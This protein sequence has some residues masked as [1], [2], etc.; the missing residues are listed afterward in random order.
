MLAKAP[1]FD[2]VYYLTL[3]RRPERR[4]RFC[5]DVVL[6]L[7]TNLFP[8]GPNRV[9]GLDGKF[10]PSIP[11]YY[12]AATWAC[13]QGHLRI[14]EHA[15]EHGYSRICVFE[16]DAQL[17]NDFHERIRSFLENVPSTWGVLLLG[18]NNITNGRL[19]P[20]VAESGMGVTG[21]SVVG[22][23]DYSSGTQCYCLQGKSIEN[24]YRALAQAHRPEVKGWP[25]V[26]FW[27]YEFPIEN[28]IYLPIPTLVGQA[29][30]YSDIVHCE[31]PAVF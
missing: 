7:P 20:E 21:P 22:I 9:L 12:S 29:P 19:L 18:A 23:A 16:D 27:R 31:R 10:I 15:L 8:P 2:Q 4:I 25:D 13:T 1:Y 3:A 24:Y 30:G 14:V 17:A 28:E 5:N 26:A 6:R 11:G